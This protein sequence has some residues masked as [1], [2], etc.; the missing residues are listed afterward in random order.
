[1]RNNKGK[2]CVGVGD[3]VQANQVGRRGKAD[4]HTLIL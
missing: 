4:I 1:V 2:D 3:R